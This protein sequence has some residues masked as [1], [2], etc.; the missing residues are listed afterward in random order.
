M[1]VIR[2]I[3][4]M[5]KGNVRMRLKI[6]QFVIKKIQNFWLFIEEKHKI[7]YEQNVQD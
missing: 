5:K 1:V 7:R 2:F 6:R 4:I 3:K